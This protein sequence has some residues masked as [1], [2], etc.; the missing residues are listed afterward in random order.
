[1]LHILGYLAVYLVGF[2]G[3]ITYPFWS[4]DKEANHFGW[5]LFLSITW[6][7]LL[8]FLLFMIAC[9]YFFTLIKYA[10]EMYPRWV[11]ASVQRRADKAK[12]IPKPSK[13]NPAVESYRSTTC[14]GCGKELA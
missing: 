2:A 13:P 3:T 6:P 9:D 11:A 10:N 5:M 4:H 7:M 8:P 1:M 14:S 12:G